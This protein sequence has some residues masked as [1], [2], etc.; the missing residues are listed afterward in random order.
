MPGS[1]SARSS[2]SYASACSRAA[3]P[4]QILATN[5]VDNAHAR[6]GLPGTVLRSMG[7]RSATDWRRWWAREGER[8]LRDVLRQAWPP[9]DGVDEETCAGLAT[10]F[11]TLLG[12]RSPRPALAAELGRM[13]AVVGAGPNA[14][15]DER[16]AER[17]AD[18]FSACD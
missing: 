3:Q 5:E 12:S 4:C 8:E 6:S 10:R 18:W 1:T 2:D 11:A 7:P 13:R 17:V 9:L 14:A 15:E 16:A